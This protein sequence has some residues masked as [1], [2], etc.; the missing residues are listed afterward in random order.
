MGLKYVEQIK[1]IV[2]TLLVVLSVTLTFTIWTYTPTYETI[3]QAPVA[4]YFNS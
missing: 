3:E 4:Q 1:S 2:L